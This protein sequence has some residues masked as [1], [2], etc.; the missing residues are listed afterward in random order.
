MINESIEKISLIHHK[1]S[2][3]IHPHEQQQIRD[4]DFELCDTLCV[5][6]FQ[7]NFGGWV[8]FEL[9]IATQFNSMTGHALFHPLN[10]H[11]VSIVNKLN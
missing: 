3:I 1:I 4:I 11:S 6:Q 8:K 7:P 2:P 5:P 9:G 10:D